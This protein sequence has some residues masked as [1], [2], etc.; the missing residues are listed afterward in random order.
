M[1]K[2]SKFIRRT[3]YTLLGIYLTLVLLLSLPPV[4]RWIAGQVASVLSD[5][6]RTEVQIGRV[7]VGL[8]GRLIVD[9]IYVEDLQGDTLLSVAR[10]G[11]KM[12]FIPLIARGDIIIDNAQLLSAHARLNQDTPESPTNFQFLLDAFKGKGEKK[13]MPRISIGSVVIRRMTASWDQKWEP[14]TPGTLNPHHLYVSDLSANV[15]LAI[16]KRDTLNLQL[17]NLSATEKS[18]LQLNHISG[19]VTGGR[20]SSLRIQDM[21]LKMPGTD[22][23]GN[24]QL[25]PLSA[26][27]SGSASTRDFWPL[28]EQ[29]RNYDEK[30]SVNA[31]VYENDGNLYIP[32]LQ[33]NN[34]DGDVNIDAEATILN[35]KD[36]DTRQVHATLKNLNLKVGVLNKVQQS[37][38]NSISNELIARAQPIDYISMQ[39]NMAYG[40]QSTSAQLDLSCG[41]GS[42]LLE[43]ELKD[44]DLS[45][46]A[47]L[48][49][50][51][52]NPII[53]REDSINVLEKIDGDATIFF[54][55][56]NPRQDAR[57]EL[58]VQRLTYKGYTYQDISAQAQIKG[59]QLEANVTSK[60]PNAKLNTSITAR[61]L[62]TRTSISMQA[63]IE[64]L[65]PYTLGV[66]KGKN[67]MSF[68]ANILADMQDISIQNLAGD[69]IIGQL[70]IT[71]T[72]TTTDLHNIALHS[73]P[74]E[75]IR[76]ITIE[77]PYAKAH[78]QG[79]FHPLSLKQMAQLI[80]HNCLPNLVKAPT[81][82]ST[83]EWLDV[84]LDVTDPE[85]IQQ[86]IGNKISFP[87]PWNLSANIDCDTKQMSLTANIPELE[88][89]G[90]KM[91]NIDLRC[92]SN[93]ELMQS[94]L[95][96]Q[97]LLKNNLVDTRANISSHDEKVDFG[98]HWDANQEI[99]N[100][101]E[102]RAEAILG[103]DEDGLLTV[104][105][106]ILP[107]SI[108]INDTVWDISQAAISHHGGCT[109]IHNFKISDRERSIA[110][111][112]RISKNPTDT[113]WA[114]I[115]RIDL[116]YIFTFVHTK[117]IKMDGPISGT[118][119]ATNLLKNP[120][121]KGDVDVSPLIFND[122]L[123]GDA[124]V[125]LAFGGEKNGTLWVHGDIE[126]AINA[127][128]IKC[129]G[130]IHLKKD[131]EQWLDLHI[132]A[133][134]ANCAL[135][136][137]YTH[138]F[139]NNVEG[140]ASG[141]LNVTGIFK[142]VNLEGS[143]KARTLSCYIPSLGVNYHLQNQSLEMRP[144]GI[145]L[146]NIEAFDPLGNPGMSEHRAVINGDIRWEHF[147]NTRFN[148]NI[149]G[150][151]ILGYNFTDFGENTFYGTVYG[152]GNVKMTGVPGQIRIDVD[153]QPQDGSSITYNVSRPETITES[154]FLTFKKKNTESETIIE[155]TK[156]KEAV[157][158]VQQQENPND[159]YLN[160]D[161]DV[162]PATTLKLIM[163]RQSGD[164]IHLNGNGHLRASYYNKGK[165]QIYGPLIVDHGIYKMSIQ[166]I[167][168][169][170]FQFQE[171]GKITFAGNP[172]DGAL[173]L[174]AIYTVPSVSLNDLSARST[175]SNT[176]VR[177]NCIMNLQG[178]AGDPKVSFDFDIPN[179]NEDE[180]QMVRSLI[181]TEEER[182]MQVIY[183]LG[184]GRFYTYESGS[185]T[186]SSTAMNSLLSTTLSGQLNQ[187]FNNMIGNNNWNIG[188]NL[189]TGQ[190]GWSDMD[191]EA[192]LSGRLLNNRLL[193]NGNFGYRDNPV[194]ASNF[195]GDFD[196][197][198]LFTKNG[199]LSLKAYSETN[200]RYFTK[201][202]LTTQGIGIM[203]KRD[204]STIK[205]LFQIKKRK[206]KNKKEESKDYM[207]LPADKI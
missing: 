115:N 81:G 153:A 151:N 10:A 49:N 42:V 54:N 39:G 14:E 197:Q 65:N 35:Y 74:E 83:R 15:R 94:T 71:D 168:R 203:A 161:L 130:D 96:M 185:E 159:L 187:M 180:K 76:D 204:F 46:H 18:G 92:E 156:S 189:S 200:D 88:I 183:L 206:K 165:F 207:H 57:A 205:E 164:Y 137:K 86:L 64:H 120:E 147:N 4:Q 66:I 84:T 105:S 106:K 113:L 133:V 135:I 89:S 47:T 98:F 179:V 134:E 69:I 190:T 82:T 58:N 127:S 173:D 91:H 85:P 178:K 125:L 59:Q 119:T 152:T 198:W 195:I 175:F 68:S 112:G 201:S 51:N 45:A 103:R 102:L 55:I 177:V 116:A 117:A 63:E 99:K 169:K 108:C 34:T 40:P 131:P 30:L 148:I 37:F 174:K 43:A 182:N 77:S 118:I 110:I 191:A 75:S 67:P 160:F 129:V 60:D 38:P 72:A 193:I 95:Q 107:T 158:T 31:S 186:Q 13:P 8:T 136:N 41:I 27:L 149:H 53:N 32:T 28:A 123:M 126:D 150:E 61:L 132:N 3:V 144:D 19:H 142:A 101:G 33:L 29:I 17:R 194:A 6:L 114:H 146:D 25:V 78:I 70:C 139:M 52:P 21:E 73:H 111:D 48:K 7:H 124:H 26:E 109:D 90:Q 56:D 87:K 141:N 104:E 44:K 20:N 167:I 184:I 11:V 100:H 1:R 16:L 128:T 192:L 157:N 166:E 172:F 2:L 9:D 22:L 5:K 50:L 12:Q 170:D 188:A 145:T 93:E 176:N 162:T 79:E 24:M 154:N 181:S 155:N 199:N 80:A 163:D 140:R 196:L 202:A 171:G 62:D 143:F 122:A 36:A 121:L 23:K 97:Y 138:A